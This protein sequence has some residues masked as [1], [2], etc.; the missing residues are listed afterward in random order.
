MTHAFNIYPALFI[1]TPVRQE[2][3]IHRNDHAFGDEQYRCE[4]E[5][6]FRSC[7]R[8]FWGDCLFNESHTQFVLRFET[9]SKSCPEL[10][11]TK[12]KPLD[13]AKFR[14]TRYTITYIPV[15]N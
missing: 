15:L 3:T 11:D 2:G 10:L 4:R 7:P 9:N 8:T 6:N 12:L 13:P 1:L 5:G 14:G